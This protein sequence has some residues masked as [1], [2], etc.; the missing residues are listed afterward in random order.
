MA[1]AQFGGVELSSA[2]A[3]ALAKDAEAYSV[4]LMSRAMQQWGSWE[5]KGMNGELR[6]AWEQ[7]TGA[8]RAA[9]EQR[10]EAARA[11]HE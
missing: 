3:H 1:C 5:K 2:T 4:G 8:L 9:R 11:S 10:E 7:L 6:P